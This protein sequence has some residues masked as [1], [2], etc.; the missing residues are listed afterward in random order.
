MAVT[1]EDLASL[2]GAPDTAKGLTSSLTE[3]RA[4]VEKYIEDNALDG[5][6]VPDAILDRATLEVSADLFYRRSA[7]HGIVNTAYSGG[8]GMSSE[9]IRI[10][11]DP[12]AAARPLLAQWVM[13]FGIA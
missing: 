1:V 3:G 12:M 11:R 8:E 13:E 4:M 6:T 5:V 10:S 7:P 2:V 9:P